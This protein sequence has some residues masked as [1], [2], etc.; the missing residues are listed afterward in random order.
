MSTVR[1]ATRKSPLAIWQAEHISAELKSKEPGLEVELVRL[2]TQGDKILDQA[3]SKVGGKDL[4][5]KEIEAALFDGRAEVAVHSLKDVPTEL[6]AGLE[7]TAFPPRED[8]RDALVSTKGYTLDT[9]PKG[10]SVGTCSLRR[11]AQLL[12]LRPDLVIKPIRGNVQTRL[13]KLDEDNLDATILAYAGLLRLGMTQVATEVLSPE[14]SLPAIGQGI[15]AVECRRDDHPTTQRV[16]QLDDPAARAAALTER[17]FLRRLQ[18]GCQVP[19]AG[20]ATLSGDQITLRGLVAS[21]DGQES[22][23][24]QI[25]GPLGDAE[26]LGTELADRLLGRGARRILDALQGA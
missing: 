5:V 7:V 1:I 11:A 9:L 26:A 22:V 20:H 13:K 25:A 8:P 23:E 17:A 12:R 10:A 14:R 3:L 18:G 21:L 6:P 19:I 16:Q 4:F 24:D 15:L 2:T